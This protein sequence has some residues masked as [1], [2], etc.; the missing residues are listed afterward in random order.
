MLEPTLVL[1]EGGLELKEKSEGGR[2]RVGERSLMRLYAGPKGISM[3][4][5]A[6]EAHNRVGVQL[7]VD[8]P[9]W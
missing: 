9:T 7:H 5:F 6:A 3:V 8:A 4:V 2:L 1:R